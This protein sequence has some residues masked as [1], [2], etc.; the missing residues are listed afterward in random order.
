MATTSSDRPGCAPGCA[1]LVDGRRNVRLPGRSHRCGRARN[2]TGR[3]VRLRLARGRVAPSTLG[4]R[5]ESLSAEFDCGP[6][7][8]CGPR[9]FRSSSSGRRSYLRV[10]RSACATATAGLG[11]IRLGRRSSL[12]QRKSPERAL[13]TVRAARLC[14]L[15]ST[16]ARAIDRADA[17]RGVHATVRQ[18]G[19]ADISRGVVPAPPGA[20]NGRRDRRSCPGTVVARR[21]SAPS[22]TRRT[23]IDGSHSAGSR[24]VS[25]RDC[26]SWAAVPTTRRFTLCMGS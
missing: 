18:L 17:A 15:H 16:D 25:G 11:T 8:Q 14:G 5:L 10:S 9:G 23:G 24:T 22:R 21:V 3:F 1:A 19:L 20:A 26:L 4:A 2:R 13:H 7:G 6:S 12:L